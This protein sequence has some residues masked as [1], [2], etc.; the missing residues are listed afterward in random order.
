QEEMADIEH[1][2]LHFLENH[3]EQRIPCE[4]FAGSAENGKPAMVVSATISTSPTMIYFGQE[5][6]ESANE[7]AGFGSPTRTSIFDYIGVPHHQRWVNN[8][9]FDGGQ[10]SD[11]ENDL[12]YFYKR[13]LNFTINS[14][15]LM[16]HYYDIHRFNR[17]HTENYNYRVFS[18]VRWSAEEK[19]III[20]NFDKDKSYAFELIIPEG[21][22]SEWGL[23]DEEY[24][25]KDQL[26][27][28]ETEVLKIINDLG[29]V[30]LNL[31]PLASLI[32]KL[33]I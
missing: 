12:R 2:M 13:L 7:K 21:L 26:Y 11:E 24:L 10:L 18:F 25:L 1:Q 23:L 33:E 4:D 3:D 8:K 28:K 6:G 15:A 9:Q 19:L 5:V 29:K 32:L 30:A 31:K 17:E 16:G 20:S 14:D 27:N 22:I